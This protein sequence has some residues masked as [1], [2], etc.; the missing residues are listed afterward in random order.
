ML[1]RQ[2]VG[3]SKAQTADISLLCCLTRALISSL[4]SLQGLAKMSKEA[5]E[6]RVEIKMEPDDEVEDYDG[7]YDCLICT[8]SVRGTS[9]LVCSECNCNPWHRTCDKESKYVEVCPTCNQKSVHVWTGSRPGTAAPSKIID[10]TGEGKSAAELGALTGATGHGAREDGAS[11]VG[12]AMV[13]SDVA[14][15]GARG[16]RAG[17]GSGSSGKG[18]EPAGAEAGPEAA[19]ETSAATG[20]G[21]GAVGGD[22]KGKG[23]GRA[24]NGSARARRDGRAG[25]S[26]GGGRGAGRSGLSGGSGGKSGAGEQRGEGGS[27]RAAPDGDVGGSS[28]GGKASTRGEGGAMRA[29]SEKRPVQG[30]RRR[31][32]R[33]G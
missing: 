12:G 2:R 15:Q 17:A 11:A 22:G 4:A 26:S 16:G 28:G 32:E 25:Q 18:K 27:K 6:A 21:A 10:L 24:D 33:S 29:Q 23:K 31:Q 14:G 8:E 13:V 9:S 7:S 5:M 3:K 19:G 30:V 20:A 1:P